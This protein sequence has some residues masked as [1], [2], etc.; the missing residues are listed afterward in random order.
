MDL[1]I[2]ISNKL[3]S[4][5]D[6]ASPGTTLSIARPQI[7][8]RALSCCF[9]STPVTHKN[10]ITSHTKTGIW[11]NTDPYFLGDLYTWIIVSTKILI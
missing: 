1:S 8:D 7:K 6:I 3:S 5:A 9:L 4:D 10:S 11:K 2:L